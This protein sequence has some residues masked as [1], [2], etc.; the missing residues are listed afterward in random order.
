MQYS[1]VDWDSKCLLFVVTCSWNR[2]VPRPRRRQAVYICVVNWLIRGFNGIVWLWRWWAFW[3]LR[4]KGACT[5]E[6][7]LKSQ[8]SLS[9][10]LMISHENCFTG[11]WFRKDFEMLYFACISN[12]CA[13][14]QHG[15]YFELEGLCEEE[16]TAVWWPHSG[17]NLS[18]MPQFSADWFHYV[19][20]TFCVIWKSYCL[21]KIPHPHP[22][23]SLPT[24]KIYCTF[25]LTSQISLHLFV[26]DFNRS[27]AVCDMWWVCEV[28]CEVHANL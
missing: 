12:V 17:L 9:C 6:R 5:A 3:L 10:N 11:H 13:A 22:P 27:D 20:V 14:C 7:K 8:S 24:D 21:L 18:R 28:V 1:S 16:K 15:L 26:Y 19:G 23:P 25:L 4:L 2:T